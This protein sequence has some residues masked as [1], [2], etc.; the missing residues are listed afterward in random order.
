[1]SAPVG[2]PLAEAV[3]AAFPV[4]ALPGVA[5]TAA[6]PAGWLTCFLAVIKLGTAIAANKK[7]MATTIMISTRVNPFLFI[8]NFLP[9]KVNRRKPRKEP[10][11]DLYIYH[12]TPILSSRKSLFMQP[13]RLHRHTAGFCFRNFLDYA[14]YPGGY[15]QKYCGAL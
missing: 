4:V 8:Y 12:L 13:E 9:S 10:Y 7:M 14:G 11:L 15:T 5:T 3:E 2:T 6:L 1:M